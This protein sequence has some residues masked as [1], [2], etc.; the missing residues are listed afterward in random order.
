MALCKPILV[1]RKYMCATCRRYKSCTERSSFPWLKIILIGV[2]CAV[3]LEY[4][5]W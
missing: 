1:R 3:V 2:I 5:A 4:V